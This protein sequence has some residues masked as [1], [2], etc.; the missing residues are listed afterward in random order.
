MI[1]GSK[2]YF[3]GDVAQ[4]SETAAGCQQFVRT[5]NGSN[6]VT[7]PSFEIYTGVIGD[8]A[9]DA[10]SGWAASGFGATPQQAIGSDNSLG[11]SEA[12]ITALKMPA[13]GGKMQT[14]VD[15][16]H[17]LSGQVLTLSYYA[18]ALSGSCNG[19]NLGFSANVAVP[20][21]A[22]KSYGPTWNRYSQ[23]F[24]MPQ[25]TYADTKVTPQFYAGSCDI[26]IDNVQLETGFAA[27]D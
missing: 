5:G 3:D 23:T 4:C 7:N 14:T 9:V 6:L 2:I 13:S 15:T 12:N 8:S 26:A 22:S 16:G 17:P 19:E 25:A 20:A 1:G 24:I 18:K 11:T 27:S 10:F 21:N